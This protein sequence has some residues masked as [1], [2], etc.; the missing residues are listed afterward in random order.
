MFKKIVRIIEILLLV[1]VL[2]LNYFSNAKMGMMRWLV[3]ENYVI[4]KG[5]FIY[6]IWALII[7]SIFVS[8]I[9]SLKSKKV[10]L[11]ISLSA[12]LLFL[13]LEPTKYFLNGRYFSAILISIIL[14][15]ETVVNVYKSN[16]GRLV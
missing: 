1:G 9:T 5:S 15:L 11:C 12:F 2:V 10:V 13:M 7:I 8:I 6:L 16:K 3:Y 4:D 14:I